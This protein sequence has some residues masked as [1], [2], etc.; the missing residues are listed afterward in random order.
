MVSL[1]KT[2]KSPGS[3]TVINAISTGYGSAFGIDL[4]I[5][6]EAKFGSKGI[7]CS[8][9]LGVSPNL[10][11][12]CVKKVLNH[13]N[14]G[15]DKSLDELLSDLDFGN[16]EGIQIRTKT[17][18]PLG[19]GLSSSS[20]LSNSV[21][22]AT[23]SLLCEEFFLNP[24][25]DFELINLGIDA[26]LEAGVTITGAFDDASASFFGGLTITDNGKRQILHQ[27]KLPEYDILVFMPDESSLSGSSDAERMKLISPYVEMAFKEAMGGN[28]FK[29]LTLNGLLYGTVLDF[30]N[31][32]ALDALS[33][34]ALAS[35]LS[36]TGSSF[37]AVV[38]EDSIDVVKDAW[39]NY[40]GNVIETK[41]NN[42]GTKII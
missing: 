13:Y 39:A 28:Y 3:A 4:N 15:K 26:S 7:D 25:S 19:S 41:V 37:V 31:N 27:E 29:A 24:L 2:V 22:M 16:G 30:N 18:L 14:I 10:M 35:G 11:N 21:V 23:A 33:A 32:I 12:I 6:C 36:G 5:E 17:N 9:D 34:G 38:E 40:D 20:T 8:S 42:E 1:A